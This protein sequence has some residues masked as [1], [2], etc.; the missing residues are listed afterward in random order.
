MSET[1]DNRQAKKSFVWRWHPH[2]WLIALIVL[3]LIFLYI[4]LAH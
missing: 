1:D 3:I 2:G 4:K